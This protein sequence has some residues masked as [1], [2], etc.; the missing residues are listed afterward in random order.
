MRC[1]TCAW[2]EK[3][4]N[5]PHL[6]FLELRFTTTHNF[7]FPN[8]EVGHGKYKLKRCKSD[9]RR[10]VR[11]WTCM[12]WT[13]Y[14][15]PTP[16]FSRVLRWEKENDRGRKCNLTWRR[17]TR[18]CNFA[19]IWHPSPYNYIFRSFEVGNEESRTE[20]I[21]FDNLYH[22]PQFHFPEPWNG[23]WKIKTEIMQI[24][25][26]QVHEMLNMCM[27]WT[28]YQ[29]PT[30]TYSRVLR[31]EKENDR[32][33]KCN[34][35]CRRC[36]RCCNFAQIWHPS[37][38]NYIFRSF[39][40]GNEKGRTEEIEFDNL[41]HHPQ[42]H[43]PEPWSRTW[44]IK[45]ENMQIR[46]SQAHEMLNMCMNWTN[47]QHPTPTFS[48]VLRW[49]KE[50]DRRRKCN[51]TWRRCTRCCN[52]AHIWHPSPYNYIFRNFEVGNEESRTEEIEFDNLY[53]HPQFHFPEP[54]N[55]TWKIKTENMQIRLLQAHEML[56]MCMNWTNYQHPTPTFSRVL[57][58]EKENDRGRKCT[59]TCRRCTRCCNFAQIWHR[60][61]SNYIFRSFEVGNEKG[62]TEEIEF[63]KLYHHPQFHFPEPW[64][65]TWQRKTENMQIRLPQAR[66]MLNMCMNWTNYQH[67]TPT[68]SRVL[69]SEK[70]NDR[71]R[72][73][74]LTCRRCTRC[75]NFAQ[76]WHPSPYNY[77]FR[78]FE[79]GN[80]KGRT[81]EIEFDNL[82]LN[83]T[84]Y[85]TTHNFI[86]PNLEVGN[87]K[88][89][90][91]Q[92]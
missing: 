45:T 86:F 75:C 91:K 78:S 23:T 42:F 24:R 19:Q 83:L 80:E 54:W 89:R 82:R 87:R 39:E 36:A 51:L 38:Y 63:D 37:P 27:N 13:N 1:W 76:I 65:G 17:C 58:W 29:H 77:I 56:N 34:L 10:C 67:P 64:S 70:E 50:N 40:V 85:T 6:H 35:T 57:R 92:M 52:F 72:K 73:C 14:Q 9:C 16:T 66:E 69:R 44:K 68:F 49:E 30:P 18:C 46:L 4:T 21:E 90:L 31:S 47:Y 11:C 33:R 2:T 28:N 60:S 22:H 62:R 25:L 3:T 8:L 55:G 84:T 5:T 15:H 74:T 48:R 7:V 81:E 59:L 79:V 43:F 20:E 12:N 71:G 53:H 41:Y 88:E 61:P 26:P 32:G